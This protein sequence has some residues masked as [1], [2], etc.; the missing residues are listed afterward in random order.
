MDGATY[1]AAVNEECAAMLATGAR[2]AEIEG[3]AVASPCAKD[4]PS[5]P[6]MI[7][8]A[9]LAVETA[10]HTLTV[11]KH[12]ADY[13][14]DGGGLKSELNAA[15]VERINVLHAKIKEDLAAQRTALQADLTAQN[16]TIAKL[17]SD[18][19]P[20][21]KIPIKVLALKWPW[22]LKLFPTGSVV[23]SWGQLSV[24]LLVYIIAAI[25]GIAPLPASIHETLDDLVRLS[26]R[27]TP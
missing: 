5:H 27:V 22:L 17:V 20:G 15:G 18:A 9:Q 14:A 3:L 21:V 16:V 11:Q 25:Y 7:R 13:L 19:R 6:F 24:L 1:I 2:A 8:Q 26:G 10:G 23:L 12:T 4:C